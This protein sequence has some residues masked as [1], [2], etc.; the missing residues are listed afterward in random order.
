MRLAQ[1]VWIIISDTNS[2]SKRLKSLSGYSR[3]LPYRNDSILDPLRPQ[4]V[5]RQLF[6]ASEL[7]ADDYIAI[8]CDFEEL[9]V[10]T[11]AL[12]LESTT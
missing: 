11:K 6:K 2:G 4:R 10:R 7:V 5:A 1:A 8:P 9:F 12:L 3:R